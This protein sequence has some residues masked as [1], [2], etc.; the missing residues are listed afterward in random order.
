MAKRKAKGLGDTIDQI[1]TATGIKALVKFVAGEDCGCDQRK[2]ALNKLFPYN[3]PNCLN[4]ADYNFLHEFFTVQRG[5]IVPSVQ[6]RL[7]E[8]HTNVFNK[9][10]N[11]T[12]CTSCLADRV[13]ALK[14]VYVQTNKSREQD[15]ATDETD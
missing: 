3:K 4:E 15:T 11:F 5:S 2:E 6:Y 10:T 14:K 1:T 12:N 9:V 8:I 13:N 7:N